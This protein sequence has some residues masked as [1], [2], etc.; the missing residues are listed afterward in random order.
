MSADIEKLK[1]IGIEKIYEDTH[2]SREHVLAV[3]ESDYKALNRV[4]FLGFIS[5]LEREYNLDLSEIKAKGMEHYRD[6]RVEFSDSSGVFVMPE[7][8]SKSPFLYIAIALIIVI[9]VAFFGLDFSSKDDVVE[10]QNVDNK[11]ILEAKKTIEA[12]KTEDNVTDTNATDANETADTNNT[13]SENIS[14]TQSISQEPVAKLQEFSIV[15][16]AKVWFGYIDVIKDKKYQKTIDEKFELDPSKEWLVVLGHSYVTINANGEELSYN[17]KGNLYLHYENGK[18]EKIT[19][20]K[21][22]I[23]NRGHQW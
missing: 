2:I 15:P 3:I 17:I 1:K 9:V 21:F 23:L 19:K 8:R 10:V 6:Q 16:K 18:V 4:Q 12:N 14:N 7:S 11:I 22:A 13:T 5:I 20:N